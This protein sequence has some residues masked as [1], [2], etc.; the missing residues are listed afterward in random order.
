[1]SPHYAAPGWI[2]ALMFVLLLSLSTS[3]FA[4]SAR[5]VALVIGNANYAMSPLRNPENDARSIHQAL[6]DIGFVSTLATNQTGAQLQRSIDTFV[7]TLRDGDVVVLHYSGHGISVRGQ[8][9]M[10]GV[11]DNVTQIDQLLNRS[12]VTLESALARVR[13][14]N[15]TAVL[16][17]DACRTVAA[18]AAIQRLLRGSDGRMGLADMRAPANSLLAFSTQPLNTASD[19]TS[20]TSPFSAALARYLRRPG[21]DIREVLRLVRAQVLTDTSG[22]Q[23]PWDHSSLTAPL[24]FAAARNTTPALACSLRSLL[25]TMPRGAN[26]T[27]MFINRTRTAL[28]FLWIDE[29]GQPRAPTAISEGTQREQQ[30]RAGQLW[31]VQSPEGQ[32]R[33]LYFATPEPAF[34]EIDP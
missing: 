16:F 10:V 28:Q 2:A 11:D 33:G 1:M 34:V 24:V 31:M 13:R 30:T 22:S 23:T 8:N 6:S 20:E 25:R 29:R 21:A 9:Y 32:C 12:S 27:L 17:F 14:R 15:V 18:D 3:A 19:G 4:Q 5:K 7:A 26:T